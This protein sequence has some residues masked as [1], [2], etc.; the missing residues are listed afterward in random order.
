MA[1]NLT[2]VKLIHNPKYQRSGPKSYV[3]LLKK[4]NISPTKEGPYFM[5]NIIHHQGKHAPG[6]GGKAHVQQHV[7]QKKAATNGQAGEV[8]SEDVQN[9]SEYLSEVAIGT[10]AQ[11]LKLDFDTGSAD[12]W[13]SESILSHS[14][15]H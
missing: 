9:D 7:L 15:C 14:V 6:V 3:Y 10:P 4:Y 13:V 5:N 2:K 12:L 11:T 1:G 8:P